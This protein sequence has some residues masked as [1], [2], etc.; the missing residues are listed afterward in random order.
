MA[1][2]KVAFYWCASCGG[3]EEAVVDL[4]EDILK[5][6]DAVDIVFWPVAL[7]FKYKDVEAMKDGEIAVSFI[8]GAVRIGEQEEVVKL[9]RKKSGLVIAFG[10]CAYLGGIPGLAN[11]WNRETI[12]N[13]VYKLVPT[14]TNE[15]GTFPQEKTKVADNELTLPAFFDTVNTVGQVIDVDYYLPGCPPPPDLIMQAVTAILE[16]KLPDKGAVLAPDK[17][18]CDTCPRGEKKPEKLTMKEIKRVHQIIPD[19]EKCFLEE[20]IICLGPATRSGCGERC[21]NGNMPCRGCF[22]PTK[23]VMDQGA[24][25]ISAIAS[26]LGLEGEENMSDEDVRKLIEQIV[27]PVGTFYRF[28]L[29]SSLLKRKIM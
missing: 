4:N 21:I 27:D 10:S 23:E 25:M 11:L 14:V 8:N 18:L 24:K 19:T 20:G 22:G 28:S 15:E 16:G 29:P 2:P 6:V 5:V 9:L 13:R 3:C 7:D 17:S 12:F 1:K 26:I